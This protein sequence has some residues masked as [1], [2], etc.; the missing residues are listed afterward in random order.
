M[1]SGINIQEYTQDRDTENISVEIN[2]E[3]QSHTLS[4]SSLK[5]N[6]KIFID[7]NDAVSTDS[8]EDTYKIYKL[9]YSNI[10]SQLILKVHLE[11][12]NKKIFK[13]IYE[14][15]LKEMLLKKHKRDKHLL[16]DKLKK[17]YLGYSVW[18]SLLLEPYENL[19]LIE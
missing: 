13:L 4:F 9:L 3:E 15:T 11:N 2:S 8:E 5:T 10:I 16:N 14:N 7:I 12:R 17:Y 6:K 19:T 18:K 1:R